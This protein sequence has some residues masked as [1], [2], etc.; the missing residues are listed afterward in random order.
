MPAASPL[1]V[2]VAVLPVIPPGFIVQLPAGNPFNTTDPVA[3]VHV[4]CV[5]VPTVGAVGGSG[6]ALMTTL[7]EA[8]DVHPAAFVTV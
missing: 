7:A 4:G 5:S 6:W 2:V 1:I 3:T 8:G